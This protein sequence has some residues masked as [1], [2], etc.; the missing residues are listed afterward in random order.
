[1]KNTRKNI[2]HFFLLTG[3]AAGCI[4]GINKIID[5]TSMIKNLLSEHTGHFFEWKYGN[6]RC[7]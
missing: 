4:Y 3:L 5:T 7:I 1:M 2:R 6:I